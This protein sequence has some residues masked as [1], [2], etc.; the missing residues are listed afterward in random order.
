MASFLKKFADWFTG[1]DVE[2][3][4]ISVGGQAV[5]EGVMMKGPKYTAIAVRESSG[6][7]VAKRQKS[8]SI[9]RKY[10]FLRWP[11]L[12]GVVN[13]V[14][15]LYS[16]MKTLMD[17][18]EM[19]GEEMEEPSKFEKKVAQVLHV[20][21]DDVM[22]ITAVVLALALA[23]GMFFVLP[24]LL[25]SLVKKVV[26]SKV[27]VNLIGGVVRMI[28]FLAYV[29]LCSRLKEI[30]RVFQYHG[31][32]H[33][34]VY[35]YEAG[36][37]LTVENARTFSTLHPRCGTS[38]LVIV[39][40]ISILVFT[41]FGTD[42]ANVFSRV[43]SRLALLPLVAGVS[44][45]ILKWLGRAKENALIRALKWPGLM[46]QKITTAEPDDKMLE[47]AICSLKYALDMP[48]ALPV[49]EEEEEKAGEEPAQEQA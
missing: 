45:E 15:M 42:S 19:A 44:Y 12:R 32:E 21:P 10:K 43:G 37:P 16:G 9:G 31:A 22:M 34:T 25:E 46:M 5:M 28:I 40:L 29:L 7:I 11:I 3:G 36:L 8:I 23:I 17:S 6:R 41:V 35:C 2:N 33:K 27:A 14:V 24:T 13:F 4:P 30:R 20:K 48:D 47:V 49:Y 38:F 1:R 39:M 26:T 18:A